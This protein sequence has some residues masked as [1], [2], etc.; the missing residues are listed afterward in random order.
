MPDIDYWERFLLRRSHGC[1]RPRSGTGQISDPPKEALGPQAGPTHHRES[2]DQVPSSRAPLASDGN[3]VFR[4]ANRLLKDHG[5]KL[6]KLPAG[7]DQ[8]RLSL[9]PSES[10]VRLS[11]EDKT[12]FWEV[13][14]WRDNLTD[15]WGEDLVFLLY[16]FVRTGDHRC[17][18][19]MNKKRQR[20]YARKNWDKIVDAYC[21]ETH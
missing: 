11:E 3:D 6:V 4:A 1:P 16:E 2:L 7:G 19:E 17:D 13:L 9:V 21:A 14:R 5:L 15:A 8:R 12:E 18:P 20:L 10:K